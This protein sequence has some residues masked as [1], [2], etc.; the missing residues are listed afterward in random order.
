[1]LLHLRL[2]GVGQRRDRRHFL[3]NDADVRSEFAQLA[4]RGLGHHLRPSRDCG[5]AGIDV[6]L[7]HAQRRVNAVESIDVLRLRLGHFSSHF[8]RLLLRALSDSQGLRYLVPVERRVISC[9]LRPAV[10][11]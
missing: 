7:Q 1:M 4:L 3:I 2:N 6:A 10:G 5:Y 8:L 9:I 11:R